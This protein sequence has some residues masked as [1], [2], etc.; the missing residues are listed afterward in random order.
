MPRQYSVDAF[1]QMNRALANRAE[2]DNRLR[3]TVG[4]ALAAGTP[5]EDMLRKLKNVVAE[6]GLVDPETQ[7]DQKDP[8]D[9]GWIRPYRLDGTYRGVQDVMDR[10]RDDERMARG[11]LVFNPR[12]R[13]EPPLIRT[14]E[15]SRPV[16]GDD[17]IPF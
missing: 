1:L 14:P 9:G 11:H 3:T 10:R 12:P 13:G 16:D 4:E 8:D 15:V 7:V 17:E 6:I 2:F 5:V